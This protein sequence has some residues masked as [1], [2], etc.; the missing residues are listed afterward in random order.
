MHNRAP[1]CV[2]MVASSYTI[3]YLRAIVRELKSRTHCRVVLYS[4]SE[5][6]CS[7]LLKSSRGEPWD[8]I[9][10]CEHLPASLAANIADP[11]AVVARARGYEAAIG[12]TYQT[13]G[14]DRRQLGR[15][16]SPGGA[17]TPRDPAVAGASYHQVLHAISEQLAFWEREIEERGVDLFIDAPKEAA[18][19][20]R[21]KGV[22]WRLLSFGRLE[23]RCYWSEDEYRRSPGLEARFRE[24]AD[25]APE[26]VKRS[27][28]AAA[29]KFERIQVQLTWPAAVKRSLTGIVRMAGK[30]MLRQGARAEIVD[31]ALGP[32]RR[33][34]EYSLYRSLARD[35]SERLRG[36]RFVYFP[37]HKELETNWIVT[38]PEYTSQQAAVMAT[39]VALP[40]GVLLAIKENLVAVG[41]RP[42]GFYR[43][44]T[45]LK[46][47]V[48]LPFEASSLDMQRDALI[49]ACLAGTAAIE[50]AIIGKP[51]LVFGRHMIHNFLDHVEVVRDHAQIKPFVEC[52][53]RGEFDAQ[54]A[55]RDGRR[56]LQAMRDTSF[57]MGA[58]VHESGFDP[59]R[60]AEIV[61]PAVDALLQSM[62]KERSGGEREAFP[63]LAAGSP[64]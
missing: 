25:A 8:E 53:L 57:D 22:A 56:L 43:Q 55:Q 31:V 49:T 26:P 39:A 19:I 23:N 12:E 63:S 36:S 1:K 61:K 28:S 4:R 27:Y 21:A 60:L 14:L 47:V 46:N 6:E 62:K 40:A 11:D 3:P 41:R 48:L 45:D 18:V 38:S 33:M 20:A 35:A 13:L 58:F 30:A 5:S 51:A 15:G 29:T 42:A 44:L 59:A 17:R 52:I 50:A 9:V 24:L 54:K 10:L 37:L 64:V 16:Y 32:I 34:R 2:G 7:G